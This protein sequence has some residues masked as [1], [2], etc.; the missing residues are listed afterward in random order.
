MSAL[1]IWN[2]RYEGGPCYAA[3]M[4]T[5]TLYLQSYLVIILQSSIVG[6]DAIME[7]E[8]S[9]I[10]KA[11]MRLVECAK[12]IQL[13]PCGLVLANCNSLMICEYIVKCSQPILKIF[14][15]LVLQGSGDKNID[16]QL[17]TN[18]HISFILLLTYFGAYL[19]HHT[20]V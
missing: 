7:Q 16:Y 12:G 20:I 2:N 14:I 9:M 6:K 15:E 19:V 5:F 8:E 11:E 18:Q 4:E 13:K 3:C 10:L 17:N 1:G